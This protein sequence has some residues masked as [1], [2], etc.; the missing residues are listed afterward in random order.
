MTRAARMLP[1]EVQW[2][3][4]SEG[5]RQGPVDMSSYRSL[6]AC[7][8]LD[9]YPPAEGDV[10][11]VGFAD[12]P[13]AVP[14]GGTASAVMFPLVYEPA[15]DLLLAA[16]EFTVYEGRRIVGRGRVLD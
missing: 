13:S 14:P 3:S 9:R 5:G 10:F 12:G 4:T 16:R 15:A 1:V 2:L 8:R 7:G 11:G 6:A